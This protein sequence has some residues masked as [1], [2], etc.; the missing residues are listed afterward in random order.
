MKRQPIASRIDKLSVSATLTPGGMRLDRFRA[1]AAIVSRN[2]G[3][4]F[5]IDA[6]GPAPVLTRVG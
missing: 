5:I 1:A 3:K 2:T 4:Q 6:T